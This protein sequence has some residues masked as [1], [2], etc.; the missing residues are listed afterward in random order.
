MNRF[1]ISD[2]IK[3]EDKI[4]YQYTIEGEWKKYFDLDTQF[5]SE[6][7]CCIEH[8]PDSIAV[9]PLIGNIIVLSSLFN[10]EIVVNEIDKDFYDSIENFIEGFQT[11]SPHLTFKKK[12]LI[13]TKNIVE[14]VQKSNKTDS[15]VF[16]SGGV[17]AWSSLI[18]HIPERP[19]LVSIWGADVPFDNEKAWGQAYHNNL[20]IAKKFELEFLTIRSTL[21]RFIN[22][23]ELDKFSYDKV[24]DNWW[25]AFQHSVGMMC[26]AAPYAFRGAKRLY[27]ASSYS[28][29]DI[30]GDYV[31]ASDP[32]IDNYVSFSGCKVIHDGYE[33]SRHDKIARICKFAKDIQEK[34]NLRVCYKSL[35]GD[36]CCLCEKCCNTIM[37]ILIEGYIPEEFGFPY[38]REDFLSCFCSGMQEAAKEEKYSFMSMYYHLQKA[39]RS[40]L[41]L[42]EVPKEL[43]LFYTADMEHLADFLYVPC[44]SCRGKDEKINYL[45][46]AMLGK[47][48]L[49]EQYNIL[50]NK[51]KTLEGDC[52]DKNNWIGKL[53]KDIAWYKS[54]ITNLNDKIKHMEE[55]KKNTWIKK[56]IRRIK[57]V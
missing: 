41:S 18:S 37:S 6:Y 26:L 24:N 53:N 1:H 23:R 13:I 19:I 10:A 40:K 56:V 2:V 44:N 15:L 4:S 8:I 38:S 48:W 17:D 16:F 21:R 12:N 54:E 43:K 33:L 51:I 52:L 50:S 36:N 39:Y 14:N 30:K 55:L 29:K 11:L 27:F 45:E 46:D 5:W 7:D 9:L 22:E 3:T 57:R 31:I 42:Q 34:I 49:E 47:D 25:S 20:N 32:I 35:I 28:E